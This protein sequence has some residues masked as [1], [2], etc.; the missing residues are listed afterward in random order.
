MRWLAVARVGKRGGRE[1][2]DNLTIAEV[3]LR[4]AAETAGE[5]ELA[6]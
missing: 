6:A 1:F 5:A 2:S 4:E 3:F